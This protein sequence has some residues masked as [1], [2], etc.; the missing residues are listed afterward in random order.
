MKNPAEILY[1]I[2]TSDISM[3]LTH[4]INKNVGQDAE[5]LAGVR[6]RV[7]VRVRVMVR[8]RVR[9]RGFLELRLG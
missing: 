6:V 9:A 7:R 5:G 1:G 4:S 8:V 2:D 3:V